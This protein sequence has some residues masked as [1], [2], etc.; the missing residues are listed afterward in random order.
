[1]RNECFGA[2]EQVGAECFAFPPLVHER[3]VDPAE[4]SRGPGLAP[5]ASVCVVEG[6]RSRELCTE[7]RLRSPPQIWCKSPMS[8]DGTHEFRVGVRPRN[9]RMLTINRARMVFVYSVC[10]A[11]FRLRVSKSCNGVPPRPVE[12]ALGRPCPERYTCRS[13]E[14]E[15]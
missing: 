6:Q 12:V 11:R 10:D 2:G 8:G 7:D 5:S 1:V 9:H 15:P 4:L 13:T 3:G 14:F